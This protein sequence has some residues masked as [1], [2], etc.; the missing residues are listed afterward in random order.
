[1]EPELSDIPVIRG[2][3][4]VINIEHPKKITAAHAAI[5]TSDGP[6]EV[7]IMT[8]AK[9]LYLSIHTVSRL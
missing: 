2:S 4:P 6:S 1:M 8:T 7:A 9:K 5:P 3:E